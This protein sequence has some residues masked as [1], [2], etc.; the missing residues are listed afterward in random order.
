MDTII[1]IVTLLPAT[2]IA[3][4]IH[5]IAHGKMA[6]YRGDPTAMYENRLSLNPLVHLEPTGTILLVSTMILSIVTKMNPMICFG[7][8][9]PVPVNEEYLEN[10]GLDVILV[11]LAGPAVNIIIAFLAGLPFQLGI[12][13]IPQGSFASAGLISMFLYLFVNINILL[14]LF[15]IIPIPPLDGSKVLVQFL[16]EEYQS[17]IKYPTRPVLIISMI[18]MF[19]VINWSGFTWLIQMILTLFTNAGAFI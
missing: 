19:A 6:Y 4:I 1:L 15:N 7:W 12:L 9:K 8:A 16:P 17:R 18:I 10:T 14:A 13:A 3:L 5:E 2:F 11:S